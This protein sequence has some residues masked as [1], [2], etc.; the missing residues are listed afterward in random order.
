MR[1]GYVGPHW[2]HL[3]SLTDGQVESVCGPDVVC[4][5]TAISLKLRDKPTLRGHRKSVVRDPFRTSA[6]EI[7]CSVR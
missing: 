3:E 6:V 2:Q 1:I 5:E 4:C 7:C